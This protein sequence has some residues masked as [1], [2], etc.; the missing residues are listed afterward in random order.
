MPRWRAVA[1]GVGVQG[2]LSFLAHLVP[3]IGHAMIGLGGG[4]VAGALGGGRARGGSEHG[5]A[6][7]VVGGLLVGL[8]TLVAAVAVGS[9]GSPVANTLRDTLPGYRGLLTLGEGPLLLIGMISVVVL[10]TIGGLL[11]GLVRGDRPLPRLPPEERGRE[12]EGNR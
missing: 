5:L 4:F 1:F 8:I 3:V 10:S 12:R 2:L 11:G 9:T 7:G 6:T